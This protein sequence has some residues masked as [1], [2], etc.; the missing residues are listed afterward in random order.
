MLR[1]LL[2]LLPV[3]PRILLMSGVPFMP[4]RRPSDYKIAPPTYLLVLL[5]VLP[6]L[7]PPLTHCRCLRP[8]QARFS[9][10]VQFFPLGELIMRQC[11]SLPIITHGTGF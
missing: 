5:L 4:L 11:S 7:S 8:A 6:L 10:I 3:L 9:A 2:L 1:L